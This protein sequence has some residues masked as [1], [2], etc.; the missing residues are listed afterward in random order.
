VIIIPYQLHAQ[1]LSLYILSMMR[2]QTIAHAQH[3]QVALLGWGSI[4]FF[5]EY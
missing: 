4:G 5:N 3:L 2:T 1:H